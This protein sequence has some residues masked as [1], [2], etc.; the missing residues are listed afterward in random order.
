MLDIKFIRENP[1]VIKEAVKKRGM[2]FDVDFLLGSDEKRRAAILER[3]ELRAKQN[4]I[5][6]AI[7]KLG[8][9]ER[10]KKIKESKALKESLLEAEKRVAATE[11]EFSELMHRLPNIPHPDVPEGTDEN[12]NKVIREWGKPKDFSFKARDHV[13]IGKILDLI[14]IERAAK[15]AGT[16]FNYLKGEAALLEFALVQ[17]VFQTLTSKETIQKI[18]RDRKLTVSDTPFIPVVPPVMIRPDLF[19]RM[20]RLNPEDKDE[21]YYLQQDDM[22]LIG[23][24]EHTLGSMH[25]DE[26]IPEEKLPIRYIG[27]STSFRRE[28]GSYGKDT[29]GILRVHQFDKLEMES[30]SAPESSY[31]EHM[32]LGAIQEYLTQALEIPY[33]VVLI[34]AGDMG[35]PNARQSDIEMWMPGEGRYRETHTADYMTDFQARRLNTKVRRTSGDTEFLHTNDAT[36]FAI[37]RTLIAIL[38]NYQEE[39]GSV[40]V[41]EVLRPYMNGIEKISRDKNA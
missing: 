32:L 2:H 4:A 18:A 41:P 17:F 30:F 38:E 5:S 11:E 3:D 21:R 20:G 15:V 39:D 16:R 9:D 36:A 19:Q 29:R 1:D 37:G 31:E 40:V 10:E 22:Y 13:E 24:A 33:R 27:F 35:K 28:A 23:S 8:S 34:C 25:A 12:D 26:S 7:A 6:D 14:D